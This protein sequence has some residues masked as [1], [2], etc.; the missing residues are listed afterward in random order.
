MPPVTTAAGHNKVFP[1]SLV[2]SLLIFAKI[3]ATLAFMLYGVFRRWDLWL[4]VLPGGVLLGLLFGLSPGR[5]ALTI[6]DATTQGSFF[7]LLAMVACILMLSEVQAHTG[8]GRRLVNGLTP[9]IKSPRLR[10]LFFPALVGLLPMPGGAIFSC[11][12]VRDVAEDIDLS[13]REKTLIN[14]WFRHVWE[15]A[16]P[17]YPGYILTC[18]LADIPVSLLWRYTCPMVPISFAVGWLFLLRKP[19]RPSAGGRPNPEEKRPFGAVM[20]EGL[21]IAVAIGAAPLYSPLFSLAGLELSAGTSFIASFLTATL[22]AAAQGGL[23]PFVLLRLFLNRRIAKMLALIFAIFAFKEILIEAQVVNALAAVISGSSSALLVL[24]VTLPV[25][26]G[27]LTGLMLGFVGTAFPLLVALLAQMDLYPERLSWM[28]LALIAGNFGQ[29][30]SP[31]HSCFLVTLEFFKTGLS[32][33][34]GT[35]A[36]AALVQFILA[37]LYTAALYF[38]FHPLL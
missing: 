15:I 28:V 22:T 24:F 1:M 18:S 19:M 29:M 37:A 2:P 23:G 35:V 20:L 16:W 31:L 27:I 5:I 38:G 30:L 4:A 9:Y 21:P 8:Q 14:Y 12:M 6:A 32:E 25:M 36:A 13:E 26:A 10:L 33:V 7:N 17:L 11:P 34:W 3:G